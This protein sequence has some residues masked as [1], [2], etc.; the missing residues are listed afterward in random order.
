MIAASNLRTAVQLYYLEYNLNNPGLMAILTFLSIGLAILGSMFIPALVKRIGKKKTFALGLVIGITADIVNFVLPTD[1][2]TFLIAFSIG[3][4]GL[5]FALGLP[6]VMVA[7]AVD[8]HEWNSGERTEGVVYSSYSFFRKLAQA[9]AGFIPGVALG[10]IAYV[11]NVQ[12][13]SETLLG[14]KGLMFMVPASLNII[15]LVILVLFYKLTDA[16][17]SKIVDELKERNNNK[18]DLA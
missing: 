5:A 2:T 12:Q 3:S 8:Y 6:W 9:L 17:Y 4:F 18:P 1:T 16:M 11:P 13:T 14:L 7:D 10:V 15:A